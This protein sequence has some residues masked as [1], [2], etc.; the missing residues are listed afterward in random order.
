[1]SNLSPEQIQ[2]QQRVVF[3]HIQ[4]QQIKDNLTDAEATKLLIETFEHNGLPVPESLQQ[5]SDLKTT[6]ENVPEAADEDPNMINKL[7]SLVTGATGMISSILTPSSS[8]P[9]D[10][11]GQATS[12]PQPGTWEHTIMLNVFNVQQSVNMLLMD[13]FGEDTVDTNHIGGHFTKTDKVGGTFVKSDKVGQAAATQPSSDGGI[14]ASVAALPQSVGTAAYQL[15][16][17]VLPP[18]ATE[19]DSETYSEAHAGVKPAHAA[20]GILATG[21]IGSVIYSYVATDSDLATS[22]TNLAKGAVDAVRR[23]G[24]VSAAADAFASVTANEYEDEREEDIGNL[25]YNYYDDSIYE[26]GGYSDYGYGY[27]PPNYDYHQ[28]EE[29]Y[30]SVKIPDDFP[31]HIPETVQFYEPEHNPWLFVGGGQSTDHLYRSRSKR[32]KCTILL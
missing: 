12:L 14:L 32:G 13:M 28:S 16:K 3:S 21:A 9:V 26:N 22:V 29:E 2:E 20:L 18:S 8:Q 5:S 1:M 17:F 11:P 19:P 30:E 25:N 6:E 7:S 23:N 15:V 4:Q 27:P 10:T 31:H 24:I